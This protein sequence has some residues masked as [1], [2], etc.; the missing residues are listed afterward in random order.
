MIAVSCFLDSFPEDAT[1]GAL[2]G[3][4]EGR[5][6]GLDVGCDVGLAVGVAVGLAVGREEGK[7]VGME[8][9]IT[10]GFAV[11]LIE[12]FIVGLREGARVGTRVGRVG[13]RVLLTYKSIDNH[14]INYYAIDYEIIFTYGE[15]PNTIPR[16]AK[17]TIATRH[18]RI[19]KSW[20]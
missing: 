5:E 2:V 4:G 16:T 15:A 7:L 17:H 19:L 14:I 1:F 13:L 3:F 9:G 8:V 6:V 10:E 20:K 18:R 11:G 12:G